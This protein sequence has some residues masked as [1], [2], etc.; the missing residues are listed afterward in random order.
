MEKCI[1]CDIHL[2]NITYYCE[3][4]NCYICNECNKEVHSVTLCLM[5]Y[6]DYEKAVLID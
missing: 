2:S 1:I 4:C 5:C 6:Y 3:S